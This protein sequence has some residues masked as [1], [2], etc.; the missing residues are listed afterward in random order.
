MGRE[1]RDEASEAEGSAALGQA[2]GRRG[3]PPVCIDMA[4]SGKLG[5][6]ADPASFVLILAGALRALGR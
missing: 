5:L 6:M 4:S 3:G 2:A 1:E